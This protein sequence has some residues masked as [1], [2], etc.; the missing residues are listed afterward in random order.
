MNTLVLLGTVTSDIEGKLENLVVQV[1][2]VT[3]WH[4]V[5][6][7]V[8]IFGQFQ[9]LSHGLRHL[10]LT[11]DE[12]RMNTCHYIVVLAVGNDKS[13]GDGSG[14]DLF[15]MEVQVKA[16]ALSTEQVLLYQ[17]LDLLSTS[18]ISQKY[19]FTKYP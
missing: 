18:V 4:R 14:H 13:D 16:I 19:Y 17:K 1:V 3:E 6:A 7:K 9:N 15:L 12:N 2:V 11:R 8:F 5:T 10:E